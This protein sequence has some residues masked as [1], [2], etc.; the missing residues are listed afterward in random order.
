MTHPEYEQKRRECWEEF[1]RKHEISRADGVTADA[2]IV[3]FD[4]ACALG[5]QEIKQEIKQE[6]DAEDTVISGWVGRDMSGSL[7]VY[8]HEPERNLMKC[9]WEGDIM[10]IS[11]SDDMFPDLTWE[12]DPI[13]VELIIKRK[14]NG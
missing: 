8:C 6:K 11:L 9:L 10:G 13:E 14:K 5:K 4:R 3:A 1:L 12:S 2:F 7:Y